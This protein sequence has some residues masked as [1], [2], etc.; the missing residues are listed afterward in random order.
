MQSV[1][2]RLGSTFVDDFAALIAGFGRVLSDIALHRLNALAR[3][4]DVSDVL[5]R[6]EAAKRTR[7]ERSPGLFSGFRSLNHLT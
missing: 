2:T 6:R 7:P 1:F 3:A 4:C 5:E